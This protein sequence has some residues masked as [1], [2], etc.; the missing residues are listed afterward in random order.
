MEISVRFRFNRATGEVEEFTVDQSSNLSNEE[1][2]RIHRD[3]ALAIGSI[4]EP[5]P[6]V[7]E[8]LPGSAT[9]T[10]VRSEGPE[11]VPPVAGT[12]PGEQ[13]HRQRAREGEGT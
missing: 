7:E 9:R 5:R 10:M 2:E 8:I 12:D 11:T 3:N 13:P 4:L 1:H 6:Q